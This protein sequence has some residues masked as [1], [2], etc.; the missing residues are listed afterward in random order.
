MS[1]KSAA[2]GEA[3]SPAEV[4]V[5]LCQRDAHVQ[6]SL[7]DSG[8]L[9]FEWD[10]V[11]NRVRRLYSAE[12]SSPNARTVAATFEGVV[13][14]VHPDDRSRFQQDVRNA[15]ASPDG[16]YA[17]KHRIVRPDGE[18][19]WL[20]ETGRV[21][22]DAV[23][24]PVRLIGISQD[25]T[26]QK[27]AENA[28]RDAEA[29][30]RIAVQA[31]GLG[32][33]DIDLATRVVVRSER[34]AEMLGQ[35]AQLVV[36]LE[37][38][39]NGVHPLDR[40]R[41]ATTIS[42][43]LDPSGD[44]LAQCEVRVLLPDGSLRWH[45]NTSLTLFEESNGGRVPRRIVGSAL[46]VTEQHEREAMLRQREARQA[47]F[48]A[49]ADR[50]RPLS[51][52][53][54]IQYEAARA[55]GTY[56]HADRVGYAEDQRDG[57]TFIVVRDYTR[58][59]QSL[60]GVY[61]YD[62]FAPELLRELRAGRSVIHSDVAR[63]E[64]LTAALKDTYAERRLGATVHVPL[65]K[66]GQ[67][68]AVLFVHFRQPH[69]LSEHD[70]TL[71]QDVAE[72]T[73]AAVERGRAEAALRDSEETFRAMFETASLGK[74]Q[75]DP[76]T[77][78]FLR[79]NAALC[80]LTGYT[81]DEL[82]QRSFRDLTHPDDRDRDFAEF[83]SMWKGERLR[84][85]SE[86]RY[87]RA[88]G[89]II[90]VR[91]HANPIRDREGRIVRAAGV[92]QDIS[93]SKRAAEVEQEAARQKDEF[94]AVLAHEL[95]NP[96]APIRT[97]VNV[98]RTRGG[99]AS[100]L[101][102][103]REIIERQVRQMA[104]LLDDLLDVSRLSRGKMTLQRAPVRLRDIIEHACET[105]RPDIDERLHTLSVD[106]ID[107]SIVLD[108]DAARLTQVFTNL[109]NNA[110]KYTN[111]G[112]RLEV[113]VEQQADVV[114]VRVSDTGIGIEPTMLDRIFDL[115]AQVDDAR[116]RADG[117]LGIGLALTRRL[118]EMHG[119]SIA[120]SS[121]GRGLGATFIVRLPL[122]S[123]TDADEWS[124]A[125][126]T[127]SE[128]RH[129]VRKRVLIVD[130]N[131]DAAN[132]MALLVSTLGCEVRAVYDGMSALR[133]A[134]LLHPDLVLLDLGMPGLDGASVCRALRKESW[135]ASIVIAAV[136]GWGQEEDRRRTRN[137]GFDHHL[138]KPVAPEVIEQ[139]V[140]GLPSPRVM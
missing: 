140:C 62:E 10:I 23:G 79:V 53:A 68:S 82:M 117:G 83:V 98:L 52:T 85:E 92:I 22:F 58:G 38:M 136:T 104:R 126:I 118:V 31:A 96:L 43:A 115:F 40:E 116:N 86:K 36:R 20:T 41:Y 44:G 63:M 60:A 74:A 47:F 129:S 48:V 95:R 54:D 135:G 42:A 87:V 64:G 131:V 65:L 19:R 18:V 66:N 5:R 16:I 125:P 72:R 49:L 84:Y 37:D 3:S 55:L 103:C 4:D 119:G 139:L 71:A 106:P 8:A 102:T 77:G 9:S 110:A 61:R 29:R 90:W 67:L 1:D 94:I 21:A 89:R 101:A 80:A 15:L 93:D 57:A 50:L 88:D 59:V 134:R 25:I 112:G 121:K 75:V 122:G 138:V 51:D 17:S 111:R 39:S 7:L 73:W 127:A 11:N 45:R 2:L 12:L 120:A 35:P 34:Y 128:A 133:E 108:A 124:P 99:D 24:R 130:D 100:V 46:D 78:R 81:E 32:T 26:A 27:Q 70:L 30:L 132:T 69:T 113:G 109:L 123:A 105:V 137:A 76:V 6:A 33:Y 97:S 13:E 114:I 28:L 14:A 107:P 56:L 91:V